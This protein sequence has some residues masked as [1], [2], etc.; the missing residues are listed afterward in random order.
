MEPDEHYYPD[1]WD[2]EPEERYYPDLTDLDYYPKEGFWKPEG[3]KIKRS[4]CS[5]TKTSG[6]SSARTAGWLFHI[7]SLTI[8]Y[9]Y[10]LVI[11]RITIDQNNEGKHFLAPDRYW[12][13][14]P[15]ID[16]LFHFC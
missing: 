16:S 5:K 9:C 14:W 12:F 1:L 11:V 8:C 3:H 6:K 10:C 7:D 4:S 15:E 2:V 13:W